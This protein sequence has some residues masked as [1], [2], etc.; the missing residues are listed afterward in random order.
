MVL[1]STLPLEMFEHSWQP[2]M[3][4]L[5]LGL[6][7][8]GFGLHAV[9]SRSP[10]TRRALL[11]VGAIHV[12][13]TFY[14]LPLP[15][16]ANEE[17]IVTHDHSF[18]YYQAY[19]AS[20]SFWRTMRL[21]RYDPY[22]MAGYPGGSLFDLD[23]KA[24]EL[25]CAFVP[26]LSVGRRLK[27]FVLL[28]YAFIVAAA[29]LGSR[30]L[31]FGAEESFLGMLLFLCV[32]HWGRPYYGDF[33]F[34]GMFS[35]LLMNQMVLVVLGLMREMWRD[36]RFRALVLLGPVTFLVHPTAI[37]VLPV[38]FLLIVA[39]SRRLWTVARA[40]RLL[41]W[42]A[43]VVVVNL[44]WLVPFANFISEKIGTTAYFQIQG[45]SGLARLLVQPTG[46]PA[47]GLIA[48]ALFGVWRCHRERRLSVA[49]PTMAGS[50]FLF[51][52]SAFGVELPG[53]NQLEPG[54]FVV[55]ALLLMV[56][57]AGV[58]LN[59]LT[60][61]LSERLP[62]VR[63]R[64][65]VIVALTVSM[66]PLALLEA[67]AFYRHTV[68]TRL[69]PAVVELVEAVSARVNPSGRLMIEETRG[70]QYGGA[71]LPALLPLYTGVEQIGGPYPD[72]F[73]RHHF[74][75]FNTKR[76][77]GRPL[78]AWSRDDFEPYLYLYNVRWVLTCTETAAER[79]PQLADVAEV[80]S[81]SQYV[82]WRVEAP[83]SFADVPG[84]EVT[85]ELD[86]ITVS[87]LEG[88]SSVVL[89]YHWVAGLVAA[90][91]AEVIPW[92]QLDDP[93]PFIRLETGGASEVVIEY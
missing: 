24:A 7:P 27:L 50:L 51:G 66:L 2:R 53:L 91:P 1:A 37:V 14:F 57:T 11:V 35:F 40:V 29:Y 82:L 63:V 62:R 84:V 15:D 4:V 90:A 74:A 8:L 47:L 78:S 55:S 28:S 58:G 5:A 38:P 61:L 31:G 20:H 64:P 22:F 52:V 70:D 60:V 48:L 19:R 23:M 69:N 42:C 68:T 39:L 34:S 92:P 81:S 83:G 26:G 46:L 32:W 72:T 33:R 6:I 36:R 18:H 43:A 17:P 71:F 45:L 75:T 89:G 10:S 65:L 80:W 30:F 67:K 49:V 87:G 88:V 21:D 25:F 13:A 56:P 9:F 41:V 86:R 77:F 12:L 16:V 59:A 79:L 76:T 85:A 93:V 73:L 3:L 44:I 54:R